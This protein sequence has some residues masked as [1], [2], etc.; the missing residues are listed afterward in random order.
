M[1]VFRMSFVWVVALSLFA[2]GCTTLVDRA[3]QK[4]LIRTPGA[5]DAECDLVTDNT[6]FVAFPPQSVQISRVYDAM[7]ITCFAPGGREKTIVVTPKAAP[8]VLFNITNGILPGLAVDHESGAMYR[9]PEVIDVDFTTVNLVAERPPSY[10]NVDTFPVLTRGL[11]SETPGFPGLDRDSPY[12][13]VLRRIERGGDNQPQAAPVAPVQAEKAA[14]DPT[15]PESLTRRY[16][17]GVF[18][19]PGQNEEK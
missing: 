11:D 10:E 9:F 15:S 8:G 14:P 13:P 3:Y 19:G 18:V 6:K 17:P 1:N 2:A 16:N 7:T 12:P 4:V 5:Q